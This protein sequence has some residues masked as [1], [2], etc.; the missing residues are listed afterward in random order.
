M[1]SIFIIDYLF[2]HSFVIL[3]ISD[4]YAANPS[5][6]AKLKLDYYNSIFIVLFPNVQS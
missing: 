5:S 1:V 2:K 6:L 3:V 4:R